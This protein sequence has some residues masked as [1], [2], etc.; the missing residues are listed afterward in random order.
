MMEQVPPEAG[1]TKR[2]QI[3]YAD[4]VP[5]CLFQDF[6]IRLETYARQQISRSLSDKLADILTTLIEVFALSR[7]EIKH[8]RLLSFGKN[9]LL[10]NDEG[11]AAMAKLANLI[12]S[13][14]GLVGAETLMEVRGYK[15]FLSRVDYNVM[16]LT[17]QVGDMALAQEQVMVEAEKQKDKG[18]QDHVKK[19]LQPGTSADDKY[20]TINR[21]RVPNTGDWIR[22]ETDF[23]DWMNRKKSIL[24]V[25]G[26][27]GAGKSFIA[28]NI[29]SYLKETY[30]Q[31][32]QHP[33]HASVAYFFFKDDN[34][35]TRSFHQALCDIAFKIAQNDPAYEKHVISCVYSPE[36]IETLQ[37]LWQRLFL[38]FF[39]ENENSDSSVYIVLDALD[40][41][42]AEDRLEFFEVAK[43][44]QQGGRLQLLMLG[45]PH[46][47]EEMDDLMSMLSISTIYVSSLNN[48]D[49][50]IHYIESSIAKSAYL[51][52]AS[53]ALQS[54]IVEKLS[55]GAQGMVS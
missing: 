28:S 40:E 53:K 12:D 14:R 32:V 48:S 27:P 44:I 37:S 9:V 26:T 55:T 21:T 4:T 19:V 1:Y 33:S 23:K 34:P 41:A 2:N 31:N 29:I 10:G 35:K 25:S 36:D 5:F 30:P 18:H 24:W 45:R 42:L 38:D 3:S 54:E 13:E 52:R 11:K 17:K 22:F 47:S 43:D 49:D 8:G 50:I 6:T 51:K 16:E 46:I 20:R 39:V 15:T 7:Q